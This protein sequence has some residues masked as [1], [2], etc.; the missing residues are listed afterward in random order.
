MHLRLQV[1][2][3]SPGELT[4][5]NLDKSRLLEQVIKTQCGGNADLLLGELQVLGFPKTY[6]GLL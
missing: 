6:I 2:G 5:L 1:A 4:E 3:L